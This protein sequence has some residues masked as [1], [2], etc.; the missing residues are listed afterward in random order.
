MFTIIGG[1]L[2]CFKFGLIMLSISLVISCSS[3]QR[4]YSGSELPAA[5]IA[6]VRS[7]GMGIF[8]ERC[9]GKQVFA[10][11]V[12]VLPGDHSIEMSFTDRLFNTVSG[13]NAVM[14]F[15]A[16][17]G[18]TYVVDKV[19]GDGNTYRMTI[20][21]VS[22][23]KQVGRYQQTPNRVE[24]FRYWLN[25]GDAFLAKKKYGDALSDYSAA[26][27][28]AQPGDLDDL[29]KKIEESKKLMLLEK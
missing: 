4:M 20:T 9:D 14:Y 15:T 24:T 21:D 17:A 8:I 11:E 25:R 3:T 29:K 18:R 5:E 1:K 13:N 2:T 22:T 6:H 23:N 19:Y 27:S 10:S 12:T 16:E 26:L 28:Y 7:A